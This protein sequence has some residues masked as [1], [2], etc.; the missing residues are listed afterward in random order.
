MQR[1]NAVQSRW[2]TTDGDESLQLIREL[3]GM[4]EDVE[5]LLRSSA[6]VAPRFESYIAR[7]R[8]AELRVS[9]GGLDYAFGAD[10]ESIRTI[11]RELHEDYLQTIG[12]GYE[13]D[14]G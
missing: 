6:K 4:I 11:M 10:V 1:L 12:R 2:D 14:E 3:A 7:L 13:P 9:N 8:V 5:R